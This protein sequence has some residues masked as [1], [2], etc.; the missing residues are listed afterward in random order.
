MCQRNSFFNLYVFYSSSTLLILF[1][2]YFVSFILNFSFRLLV[3]KDSKKAKSVLQGFAE[4]I[5][6]LKKVRRYKEVL[7]KIYVE[8]K[9]SDGI[10]LLSSSYKLFTETSFLIKVFNDLSKL[11]LKVFGIETFDG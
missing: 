5:C 4:G 3:Q 1:P 10:V 11:Y 7:K 6:N 2:L 8:K 9:K